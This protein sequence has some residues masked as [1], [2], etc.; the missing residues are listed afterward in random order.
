MVPCG[1]LYLT[2]SVSF[3]F[4]IGKHKRKSKKGSRIC[5]RA[6]HLQAD[7]SYLQGAIPKC[8]DD[9]V[10]FKR[11]G[12]SRFLRRGG[13]EEVAFLLCCFRTRQVVFSNRPPFLRKKD[14][15][16]KRQHVKPKWIR[17]PQMTPPPQ[18]IKKENA[19][20]TY[21]GCAR[22]CAV[23]RLLLHPARFVWDDTR[24]VCAESSKSEAKR[25]KANIS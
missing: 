1:C 5:Q 3:L 2:R 22:V 7:F 9:G 18:R 24:V 13:G 16:R 17:Q 15:K 25:S 20:T 12:K 21:A 19:L 6:N 11:Q 4:R 10:L 23:L 8:M 14:E